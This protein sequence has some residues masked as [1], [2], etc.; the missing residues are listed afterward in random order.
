M[1]WVSYILVSPGVFDV[2]RVTGGIGGIFLL[3]GRVKHM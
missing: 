3:Y 1:W 2:G